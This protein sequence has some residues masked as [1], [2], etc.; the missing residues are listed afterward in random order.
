ML[1]PLSLCA[2]KID[3]PP[4]RFSFRE[5][6]SYLRLPKPLWARQDRTDKIRTIFENAAS[7]Y[8]NGVLVWGHVVQANMLLFRDGKDDCPGEL[9]YSLEPNGASTPRL[10]ASVA[11]ELFALKGTHPHDRGLAAIA[12][13]LTDEHVR[14]F[15]LPVPST[16][17]PVTPCLVSTTFFCRKH[18]P[19]GVISNPLMPILVNPSEPYVAL[20]LPARY[21]PEELLDEC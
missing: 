2:Q 3:D 16:I 18:L 1:D 7:V 13:Y 4:R 5:R 9:V 8:R 21:W 10:L 14:V 20:P 17:S 6:V 11:R 12:D 15:G 19:N